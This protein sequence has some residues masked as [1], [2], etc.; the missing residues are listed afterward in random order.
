MSGV[1]PFLEADS[2]W[3]KLADTDHTVNQRHTLLGRR[4]FNT[5]LYPSM[6]PLEGA[7]AVYVT[8]RGA[9]AAFSF[10]QHLSNQIDPGEQRRALFSYS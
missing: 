3:E 6:L 10:Y 5:H 2:T 9:D 7:K 1:Q 4:L 8:R